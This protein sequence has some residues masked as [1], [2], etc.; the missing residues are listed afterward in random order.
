MSSLVVS[1]NIRDDKGQLIAELKDNQWSHQARPAIFDRNHTDSALE[2]RDSKGDIALQVVD[3]GSD[4]YVSGVFHCRKGT[5]WT[6]FTYRNPSGKLFTIIVGQRPGAEPWPIP[7]ICEYPSDQKLGI[8][9][10]IASVPRPDPKDTSAYEITQ[11]MD[12]CNK[13][14]NADQTPMR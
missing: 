6:I 11:S 8:C 2:I 4:V 10:R 7:P 5:S 12:I 1:A 14:V 9:P 13:T 3:F